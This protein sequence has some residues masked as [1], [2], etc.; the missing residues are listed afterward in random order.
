[1]RFM[2]YYKCP[3]CDYSAHAYEDVSTHISK[4]GH[5]TDLPE[6]NCENCKHI[7]KDV[8]YDSKL[9]CDITHWYCARNAS[10]CLYKTHCGYNACYAFEQKE[11]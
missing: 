1:M 10:L 7:C 5:N 11:N 9:H 3:Y 8:K 6:K 4:C 2:K